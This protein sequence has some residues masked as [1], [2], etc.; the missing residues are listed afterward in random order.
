MRENGD[1]L[2]CFWRPSAG[3]QRGFQ[4]QCFGSQF[5]PTRRAE[6]SATRQ[7]CS[8]KSQLC[9]GLGSVNIPRPAWRLRQRSGSEKSR[10]AAARRRLQTRPFPIL[11]PTHHCRAQRIALDV[12][13]HPLVVLV[14]L[15]GKRFESS[16]PNVP[17]TLEMSMVP[18]DVGSHEPL[19]PPAQ[20]AIFVRPQNQVK[21]IRHKAVAAEPHGKA[22]VRLRHQ[23]DEGSV[24]VLLV[25]DRSSAVA[26]IEDMVNVPT[27]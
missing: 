24:V 21:V 26:S 15:D 10:R 12:A 14:T 6:G 23:R 2:L 5:L 4:A 22:G 7:R 8:K 25:K 9:L 16:L 18:A 17:T 27:L 19:H 20:V 11:T 3:T 1:I 13:Q